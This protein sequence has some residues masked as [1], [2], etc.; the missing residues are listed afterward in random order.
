MPLIYYTTNGS[1]PSGALGFGSNTTQAATLSLDHLENDSSIAGNAMWWA[2][3]VS[4]LPAFTTIKYKIS[5]W[6][7]S[8]NEE[9][10]ADY[11][12]ATNNTVFSFSVG[13]S[14]RSHADG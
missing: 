9:K 1:T 6:H 10:F 13:T 5:A 7:S 12:A 3:T 14:G 11:N 4:N 8:N 2:G